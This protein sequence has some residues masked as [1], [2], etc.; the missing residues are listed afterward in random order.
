MRSSLYAK[1][2]ER[3]SMQDSSRTVQSNWNAHPHPRLRFLMMSCPDHLD[4]SGRNDRSKITSLD[5]ILHNKGRGTSN[6][7]L[8]PDKKLPRTVSRFDLQN[9]RSVVSSAGPCGLR[10]RRVKSRLESRRSPIGVEHQHPSRLSLNHQN[11]LNRAS[12]ESLSSPRYRRPS[13]VSDRADA[14]GPK[15]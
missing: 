8:I 13:L 1:I 12:T 10:F 5:Q 7:M 15:P 3:H 4:V 6:A 2:A 14:T 9:E 11:S